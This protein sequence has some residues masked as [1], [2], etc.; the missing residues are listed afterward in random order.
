MADLDDMLNDIMSGRKTS[1]SLRSGRIETPRSKYKNSRPSSHE[2][3][4]KPNE[5]I[6][7]SNTKSTPKRLQYSR[8]RPISLPNV[9][10]PRQNNT[11][12][13]QQ[14]NIINDESIT[15]RSTQPNTSKKYKSKKMNSSTNKPQQH[16]PISSPEIASHT[17]PMQYISLSDDPIPTKQ[18]KKVI[19][20]EKKPTVSVK[21]KKPKKQLTQKE[22]DHIT[23]NYIAVKKRNYVNLEAGAH[24]CY[25]SRHNKGVIQKCV[26]VKELY[27]DNGVPKIKVNSH[28]IGNL[29]GGRSIQIKSILQLWEKR[30]EQ[31]ILTQKINDIYEFIH[32]SSLSEQFAYFLEQKYMKT[33]QPF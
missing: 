27:D 28:G 10:S 19:K 33:T 21:S 26:L 14:A 30:N 8:N 29:Y 22:V 4:I 17:I 15:P 9:N 11:P 3:I 13:P 12:I 18:D 24:I 6:N 25:M 2:N 7:I 1:D 23:R 5:F 31:E 32:S 20:E 16:T